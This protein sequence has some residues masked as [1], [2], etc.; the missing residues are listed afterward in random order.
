VPAGHDGGRAGASSNAVSS[1]SAS[2]S[3]T[4]STYPTTWPSWSGASARPAATVAGVGL[5]SSASLVSRHLKV[6]V[7]RLIVG[8]ANELDPAG[9][10]PIT[11]LGVFDTGGTDR[12]AL[13]R[14]VP[15]APILR[16]IVGHALDR[17]RPRLAVPEEFAIQ[18]LTNAAHSDSPAPSAQA[19]KRMVADPVK[20][21]TLGPD[22]YRH[23]PNRQ[24]RGRSS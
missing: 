24:R 1:V 18:G 3:N 10:R 13:R 2:P 20:W 11:Q 5:T 4:K 22:R 8:R 12:K 15:T 14:R 19:L 6:R 9:H 7:S 16:D 17:D 21:G 23:F